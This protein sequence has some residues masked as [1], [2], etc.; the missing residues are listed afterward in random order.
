MFRVIKVPYSVPLSMILD[1]IRKNY[2]FFTIMNVI[3][4]ADRKIIKLMY[5]A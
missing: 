2:P 5:L 4:D 3:P 1:E